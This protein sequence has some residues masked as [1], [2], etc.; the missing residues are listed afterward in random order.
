MVMNG[1]G[2]IRE[3]IT[4]MKAN[5]GSYRHY[6]ANRPTVS[7]NPGKSCGLKNILSAES[8]NSNFYFLVIE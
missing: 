1:G 6:S 5:L 2:G 8:I 7:R 3:D 4:G